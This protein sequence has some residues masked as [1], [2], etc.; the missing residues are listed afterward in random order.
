MEWYRY[1]ISRFVVFDFLFR[2]FFAS[3][4]VAGWP[5][6]L[7]CQSSE[8][9]P[10][11]KLEERREKF[12]TA[13][14]FNFICDTSSQIQRESH[15]QKL[16][17]RK[18][19]IPF[20][21]LCFFSWISWIMTHNFHYTLLH[22]R[23][24]HTLYYTIYNKLLCFSIWQKAHPHSIDMRHGG[25]WRVNIFVSSYAIPIVYAEY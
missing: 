6:F 23:S 13:Q 22:T 4:Y 17:L 12:S 25:F 24:S 5:S 21:F 8:W 15:D 10:R 11:K 3:F 7:T 19:L 2:F 1:I 16:L 20:S 18:L 9:M 14:C